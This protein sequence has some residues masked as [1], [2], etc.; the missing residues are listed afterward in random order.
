MFDFKLCK[1]HREH[2]DYSDLELGLWLDISRALSIVLGI[3]TLFCIL[4]F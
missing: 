4:L 3:I 1:D 2:S